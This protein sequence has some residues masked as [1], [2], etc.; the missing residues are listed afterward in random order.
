MGQL[1]LELVKASDHGRSLLT[2]GEKARHSN[3]LEYPAGPPPAVMR[4]PRAVRRARIGPEHFSDMAE[5]SLICVS[6]SSI[7]PTAD[8]PIRSTAPLEAEMAMRL[9][10]AFRACTVALLAAACASPRSVGQVGGE[11]PSALT[12]GTLFGRYVSEGKYHLDGSLKTDAYLRHVAK[13]GE[14]LAKHF[15]PEFPLEDLTLDR[16]RDYGRL[17]R[18]GVISGHAARTSTIHRD[19]G[20]LKAA[21]NWAVTVYE[22]R[23]PLLEHN[24]LDKVKFPRERDP[25]RPVMDGDTINGLL[26]VAPRSIRTFDL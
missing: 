7:V 4:G 10:L 13:T 26:A 25:K 19:L 17:R 14:H 15:G 18:E 9:Y 22:G 6:A 21:L 20:M 16:I 2:R 23:R 5:E 12:L 8:L 1:C 11:S 3:A 24:P